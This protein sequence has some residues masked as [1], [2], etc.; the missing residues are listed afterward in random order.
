MIDRE[1]ALAIAKQA[2]ALGVSRGSVYYRPR[3]VPAADLAIMRRMDE[4]HIELPFAG[5]RRLPDL[6]SQEGIEIGRRHVSTLMKRGDGGAPPQPE[7]LKTH[8]KAQDRPIPAAQDDDRA[9]QP[10]VGHGHHRLAPG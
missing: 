4:L 1:H 8:P 2:K 9:S 10:G 7:H 6:L 5:S 3:P